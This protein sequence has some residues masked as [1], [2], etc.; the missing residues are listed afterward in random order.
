MNIHSNSWLPLTIKPGHRMKEAVCQLHNAVQFIALTGQYYVSKKEDDS[1]TSM[2]WDNESLSFIG[3]LVEGPRPFR[4]C[5]QAR[6]M[7]L[8][9][10]DENQ[11]EINSLHLPGVTRGFAFAWL[12]EQ[13]SYLGKDPGELRNRMHYAI[14]KHAIQDCGPFRI[15]DPE[16]FRELSRQRTNAGLILK[17]LSGNF[18]ERTEIAVWPHHFDTGMVI[19]VNRNEEGKQMKTIGTG[20]AVNDEYSDQPYFYVNIWNA[21]QEIKL[22]DLP[23]LRL[24]KWQQEGWKGALLETGDL[25]ELS[26]PDEQRLAVEEFFRTAINHSLKVHGIDSAI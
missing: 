24:G 23:G 18:E 6:N 25:V 9:L 17:A 8:L 15:S 22:A 20:Y 19:I 7:N 14:P 21:T 10:A 3:P 5:L 16:S 26:S 4:A 1:H 11:R 2:Q 12:R 13:V